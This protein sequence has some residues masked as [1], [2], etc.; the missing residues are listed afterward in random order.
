MLKTFVSGQKLLSIVTFLFILLLPTQFGKH[1]FFD[2]SYIYAIRADYLALKIYTTDIL[3]LT[4]ILL[5]FRQIII[6]VYQKRIVLTLLL[7]LSI[8]NVVLSSQ[9]I[10][11]IY[12]LLKYAEIVGVGL[13]IFFIKPKWSMVIWAFLIG[14]IG[15]L[16]LSIAQMVHHGSIG[17]MFYFFGERYLTSSMPAVAKT[18][19]SGVEILRPYGTFSHP[20]S[21]GGFYLLVYCLVL[22]YQRFVVKYKP[23]VWHHLILVTS[24][25]LVFFSFSKNAIISYG[26]VTFLFVFFYL[27]ISCR[28]CRVGRL[29]GVFFLCL[30]FVSSVNNPSSISERFTL[31]KQGI[32][33]FTQKPI[34]GWGLGQH[35]YGLSHFAS[36]HPYLFNQPIHNIFLLALVEWGLL[37][38]AFISAIFIQ[39]ARLTKHKSTLLIFGIVFITGLFDHYWLTLQQNMLLLGF[40]AGI[41]FTKTNPSDKE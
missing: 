41:I 38:F 12:A 10:I 18:Y 6:F 8:I 26:L 19:L 31:I 20:N 35:L 32:I 22:F 34:F 28:L 27:Q 1:F 15:E 13:S 33:L 36:T 23:S 5:C 3:A 25:L 21:L 7:V 4:L 11:G 40:V 16:L 24:S 14:S 9:P 39:V 17:G 30:F 37:L 2:F 29:L